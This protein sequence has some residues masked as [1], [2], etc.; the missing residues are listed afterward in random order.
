MGFQ[1]YYTPSSCIIKEYKKTHFL[2]LLMNVA[3]KSKS[4]ANMG[5]KERKLFNTLNY[6]L[7]YTTI[8]SK[9]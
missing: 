1:V 5:L 8:P 6:S 7:K 3:K 9:K 4:Q 2:T